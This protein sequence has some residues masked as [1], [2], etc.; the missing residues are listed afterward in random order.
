LAVVDKTLGHARAATT[1]RYA[2]LG[3]DPAKVAAESI[4]A[5]IER[6]SRE[7]AKIERVGEDL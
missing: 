6:G 1:E 4:G 2:H 5:E 7:P 3:D